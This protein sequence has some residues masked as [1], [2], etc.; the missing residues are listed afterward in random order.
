MSK[1]QLGRRDRI[2]GKMNYEIQ[3]AMKKNYRSIKGFCTACGMDENGY[4]AFLKRMKSRKGLCMDDLI[5]V[6]MKTG[7]KEEDFKDA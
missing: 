5:T 2:R 1:V 7:W 4:Q 3:S 6:I